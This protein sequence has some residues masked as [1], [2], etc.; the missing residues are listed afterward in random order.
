MA[1][2]GTSIFDEMVGREVQGYVLENLV[3]KGGMAWVFKALHKKLNE[4]MAVKVLL[5]HLVGEEELVRRFVDEA[6][7]QFKLKHPNIVQVTDIIEE[8]SIIGMVMEWVDGEN[9]KQSMERLEQPVS[10]KDIWRVMAPVLDALGFA[11]HR[12]LVHRDIKPANILLH[13]E[14]GYVIPKL[15]DFGIAKILGEEGGNTQTGAAMGTLKFMAPEQIRDSKSVDQRADIYALGMTLFMMSTLRFPFEGS[16]EWIIYQQINEDPPPPSTFNPRL[17]TAFDRVVLKA[18]AKEPEERFQNCAE[19]GHALSLALLDPES[20]AKEDRDLS[21]ADI[22]NMLLQ[23]PDE[24]SVYES[25]LE[26]LSATLAQ[27]LFSDGGNTVMKIQKYVLS[28]DKL[29][30]QWDGGSASKQVA[31]GLQLSAEEISAETMV[32]AGGVEI[33]PIST[34]ESKSKSNPMVWVVVA[35][36]LL[37]GAVGGYFALQNPRTPEPPPERRTPRKIPVVAKRTVCNDGD[38]KPCYTGAINTR[39]TGACKAGVRRC[40]AGKYGP[41]TG[42]VLPTK[43]TCNGKDDNCN[44]KIDES[45]VKK[46]EECSLTV[47]ECKIPGRYAC[48]AK[49]QRVVCKRDPKAK[50]KGQIYLRIVNTR[51]SFSLSYRRKRRKFSRTYCFDRRWRGTRVTLRRR[52]YVTCAF[53]LPRR[54]KTV[55]LKMKRFSPDGLAP[56]LRYCIR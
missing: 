55:R 42:Q 44:G 51:R 45:F 30:T 26:P 5:P 3:G 17:S 31:A 20:I 34:S 21:T 22:Y 7:I 41:C 12:G 18:L 37:L 39:G 35:V 11:H 49:K 50:T 9:L 8:G 4:H 6:K 13:R 36:V 2:G 54:S 52:G 27:A 19:L 33:Q 10:R 48:D 53:R 47:G 38:L 29:A 40:K 28:K 15:A 14:S 43:E 24:N 25:T 1:T 56:S 16:Q 46:D 23:L 32:H